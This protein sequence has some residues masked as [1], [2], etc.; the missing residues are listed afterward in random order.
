MTFARRLIVAL[1]A[2][3]GAGTAC[4]ADC[5]AP[6]LPIDAMRQAARDIGESNYQQ[7]PGTAIVR[8]TFRAPDAAPEV[9]TVFAGGS[10]A[11]AQAL[12]EQARLLRL[13]CATADQPVVSVEMHRLRVRYTGWEHYQA[14]EPRLKPELQLRD[15]VR[16]VKD[17]KSQH[18]KFDT[19]EMGCPFD[20]RFAPY[21][22][23][24]P[25]VAEA[26]VENAAQRAPLLEW[27]RNIT[28]DLPRDFM[29]T[30]I[31]QESTVAVPC[32]VLDL[33]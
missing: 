11:F 31:G 30:A 26:S 8:V 19:R 15:V 10:K 27:M 14:A 2:V 6:A 16:L 22:P 17:L 21:R 3:A 13:P 20:V 33:S 32:A 28:L 25:N 4:A 18:V 7:D 9:E 23:Y 29:N 1:A 5:K 12:V 24:L